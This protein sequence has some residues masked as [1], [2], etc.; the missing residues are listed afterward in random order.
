MFIII[1]TNRT[2]LCLR[3][4][5]FQCWLQNLKAAGLTCDSSMCHLAHS[6]SPS[7]VE[8]SFHD[9][10]RFVRLVIAA[11]NGLEAQGVVNVD[12]RA[13]RLKLKVQN[14]T[15]LQTSTQI[16]LLSLQLGRHL[17]TPTHCMCTIGILWLA[18]GLCSIGAWR[19][20]WSGPWLVAC[21]QCS[22]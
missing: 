12:V 18:R 4:L 2:F 16:L 9:S 19:L 11:V 21:A 6:H 1:L 17:L 15:P 10:A 22:G 13:N 7:A 14:I 8:D 3:V 5:G 20:H